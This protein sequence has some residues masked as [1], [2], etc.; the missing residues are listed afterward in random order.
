MNVNININNYEIIGMNDN[1][2]I[3]FFDEL[4]HKTILKTDIGRCCSAGATGVLNIKSEA[5]NTIHTHQ[6]PH[7][8]YHGK[9]SG[10][11]G[12]FRRECRP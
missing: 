11:N 10:S 5:G 6:E 2:G 8:K 9:H 3:A 12:H 4:K 1:K 7:E